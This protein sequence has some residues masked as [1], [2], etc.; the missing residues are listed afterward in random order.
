MVASALQI[1]VRGYLC[2][3]LS[4]SVADGHQYVAA[5]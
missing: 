4:L 2:G 5:N 3:S 1:E